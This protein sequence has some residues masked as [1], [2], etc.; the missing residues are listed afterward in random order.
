MVGIPEVDVVFAG[1]L[2]ASPDTAGE[3]LAAACALAANLAK[4]L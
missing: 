3:T 1:G 2:D 4:T